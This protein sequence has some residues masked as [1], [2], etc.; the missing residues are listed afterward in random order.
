M[1][2]FFRPHQPYG[3]LTL[4]DIHSYF[5]L[6]RYPTDGESDSDTHLTPTISLD[7]DPLEPSYPSYHV[8]SDPFEPSRPSVICLTYDSSSSSIAPH[9]APPSIHGHG[10]IC[11]CTVP[12]GHGH[13][14]G[15]G[16]DDDTS[17]GFRLSRMVTSHSTVDLDS[18]C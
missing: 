18:N 12:R 13:A 1:S 14:R 8:E 10:F 2:P 16:R 15:R 11:T 3:E 4:D 5:Q 17:G 7:S 6:L 9:H